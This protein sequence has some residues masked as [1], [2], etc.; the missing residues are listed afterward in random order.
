MVGW[1]LAQQSLPAVLIPGVLKDICLTIPCPLVCAVQTCRTSDV[2]GRSGT[3]SNEM[4]HATN[5]L[6]VTRLI[7]AT[8]HVRLLHPGY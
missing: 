3:A 8:W 4:N 6:A 2:C 5:A 1:L 7:V